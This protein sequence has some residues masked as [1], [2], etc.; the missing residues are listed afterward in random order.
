MSNRTDSADAEYDSPASSSAEHPVGFFNLGDRVRVRGARGAVSGGLMALLVSPAIF[1]LPI[2][3]HAI[4]L[5]SIGVLCDTSAES[6]E[7]V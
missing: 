6:V 7:H 1:L 4:V 5:A 2:I 3:G